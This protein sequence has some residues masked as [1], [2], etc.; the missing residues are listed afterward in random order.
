[1]IS[2]WLFISRSREE[3]EARI[4]KEA[5]IAVI[6]SRMAEAQWYKL[7]EQKIKDMKAHKIEIRKN[8]HN[9]DIVINIFYYK[10]YMEQSEPIIWDL[11]MRPL[12]LI[13]MEALANLCS[14]LIGASVI[15]HRRRGG[16][17]KAYTVYSRNPPPQKTIKEPY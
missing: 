4:E 12:D 11:D 6:E 2:L 9:G 8:S 10:G 13:E 7:L 15:E 3:K 17:W 16:D 5:T 1:M 14:G